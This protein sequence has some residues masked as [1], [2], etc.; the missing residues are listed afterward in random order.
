[1]SVEPQAI[2]RER[3]IGTWQSTLELDEDAIATAQEEEG[4]DPSDSDAFP[5]A[6]QE[7][8]AALSVPESVE[9]QFNP[10][11]TYALTGDQDEEGGWEFVSG[12]QNSATIRL[13]KARTILLTFAE[14][15]R[16][17]ADPFLF[18]STDPEGRK[19]I[20]RAEFM[21]AA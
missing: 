20:I 2:G 13:E 18:A 17:T 9:L 4:I 11:G 21:R 8:L 10:D 15:G 1:M 6:R 16:F 19:L 12:T 14:P 5:I 3:L 7:F